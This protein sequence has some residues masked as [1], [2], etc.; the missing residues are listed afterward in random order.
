MIFDC[1]VHLPS[2]GLD[3]TWE[4]QPFT[5]GLAAA[6]RYLRR[7]GVDRA[8][9]NSMR[10][11]LAKTPEEMRA[12]NDETAEAA[13]HDRSQRAPV[14]KDVDNPRKRSTLSCDR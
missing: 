1:H 12:A 6:V 13:R 10:G 9:A 14:L 2:P 3:R 4:W 11:E 7:C 8:I 5:P